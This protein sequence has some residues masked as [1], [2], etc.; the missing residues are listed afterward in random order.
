MEHTQSVLLENVWVFCCK[1]QIIQLFELHTISLEN[2]LLLPSIV[3]ILVHDLHGLLCGFVLSKTRARNNYSPV[4]IETTS[5]STIQKKELDNK[6]E[7]KEH[8]WTI[9]N[10]IKILVLHLN[11]SYSCYLALNK[12]PWVQSI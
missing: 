4:A 8:S 6:P 7:D 5:D 1:K 9:T 2:L 3:I 11:D 12:V 10:S